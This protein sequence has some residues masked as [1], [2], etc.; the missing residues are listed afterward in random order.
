MFYYLAQEK[1]RTALLSLAITIRQLL[2]VSGA[3]INANVLTALVGKDLKLFGL[4]FVYLTLVWTIIICLDIWI[5]KYQMTLIQDLSIMMRETVSETITQASF[6]TFHQKSKGTYVSWLNNDIQTI[7]RQGYEQLFE[8]VYGVSGAF[9]SIILLVSYHWSLLLVTIIG[10][11]LMLFIPR[12]FS[13]QVKETSLNTT[14]QNERFLSNIEDAVGGYDALLALNYLRLIPHKVYTASLE[15]KKVV[16][17]Q[18]SIEATVN[19]VGFALNVFLQMIVIAL[20]GLL[21]FNGIVAIGAIEA[22]GMLATIIFTSLSSLSNQLSAINGVSPIFDK[23]QSMLKK[24]TGEK[25]VQKEIDTAHSPLFKAKELSF[26]YDNT[27]ILNHLSFDFYE[28]KKYIIKGE[29]GS[30]K[31]TLLRLLSGFLGS[32][33]GNLTFY[34]QEIRSMDQRKIRERVLYVDQQPYL[35]SDTI[36]KNI[37]LEDKFTDE[38]ILRALDKVGLHP[39]DPLAWL[40][41]EVGDNGRYL[42]GGQ[43]QRITLVRGFIRQRDIIL[44]DE[45][46]SAVDEETAIEI[47]KQLLTNPNLTVILVTHSPNQETLQYFDE[48]YLFPDDFVE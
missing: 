5:K 25:V 45:G 4:Q 3:A 33:S 6:N 14:V 1:G 12:V 24:E 16:L 42:S 38:E 47:E 11:L 15:L 30:G 43:R 2:L 31:S 7:N 46:T 28:G 35:F 39:E 10:T 41:T 9:F 17:K 27:V 48:R 18:I 22:T 40:D 36:R 23:V 13:Q 26:Q 19:A 29:S 8:I 44:I 32:Y 37:L 34:N 21:A 20:T